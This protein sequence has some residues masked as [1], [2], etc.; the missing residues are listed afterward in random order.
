MSKMDFFENKFKAEKINFKLEL[1][2]I[3]KNFISK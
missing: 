3:S 1:Y 2:K